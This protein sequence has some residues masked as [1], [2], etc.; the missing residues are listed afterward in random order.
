MDLKLFFAFFFALIVLFSGNALA[1]VQKDSTD[2]VLSDGSRI[3]VYYSNALAQTI[4]LNQSNLIGYSNE[5]ID[6]GNGRTK[7]NLKF[8]RSA[9]QF[10]DE[11]NVDISGAKQL[12]GN[13][14]VTENFTI[15]FSDAIRQ[16]YG[17]RLGRNGTTATIT[18]SG[19]A[20]FG[21]VITI[22]PTIIDTSRQPL[23]N[24]GNVLARDS[25]GN[26]WTVYSEVVTSSNRD[27]F[28]GKSTNGGVNFSTFNLT[29][30]SDF[31]EA[32]PHIDIN[33]TDG[34]VISYDKYFTNT[35]NRQ[36][37]I[38]TCSA[39]GCDAAAEF[40]ADINV[41][42]CLIAQLCG[43]NSLTVDQNN[44]AHIT[45]G[46]EIPAG[47][48]L[49]YRS[50]AGYTG[51][52][53][54]WSADQNTITSAILGSGSILFNNGASGAP[55]GTGVI[56]SKNG[57]GRR[58]AWVSANASQFWVSYY[59]GTAWQGGLL[60]A[61]GTID[62]PPSCYAGY[63][64][65]FFCSYAQDS[66]SGSLNEQLHFRQAN[67]DN[68][69][70][71]IGNWS[72]DTNISTNGLNLQLSSIIQTFDLNTY[73]VGSQVPT[74]A[75]ADTNIYLF[76]RLP[77]GTFTTSTIADQNRFFNDGNFLFN[78]LF[79]D[80]D[81][82]GST[83]RFPTS[84]FTGTQRYRLDYIFSTSNANTGNP[85]T[86]VF[87][88]NALNLTDINGIV[89]TFT[90]SIPSPLMLDTELGITNRRVD[91]NS[92][93]V[94]SGIID[95]NYRWFVNSTNVST[96]QNYSR[97]FNG[98]NADYNISLVVQGRSATQTFTSQA[99]L[100]YL[101]RNLAQG[102]DIN[103]VFNP[104][105][106]LA[107][108]N[109]TATTSSGTIN[110]VVW[111]FP[112]DQNQTGNPVNKQYRSGDLR[113]VCAVVNTTGDINKVYCEGF[114]NTFVLVKRPINI[115]TAAIATPYSVTV[116]SIPTQTYNNISVDQNFW[117]FYQN[118]DSNTYNL[119]VD[120]NVSYYVS[121]YLIHIKATDFNQTI[122]PY[123]VPVTTGIQ[124]TFTSKD[125]TTNNIVPNIFLFFSRNI[126][127]TGNVLVA[128]GQTD[129]TGRITLPFI[130]NVDHNF[131]IR[132]PVGAIILI[133]TYNPVS[134]DATNGVNVFIPTSILGD[135]N[136]TGF[137]D[138]NFFQNLQVPVKAN[139]TVDL[140][141][142]VT[143]THPISTITITVDHNGAVLFNQ[144]YSGVATG[145]DFNQN[146]NV[147]GLN[148][149]VPLTITY[150]IN[151]TDGSSAQIKKS[152]QIKASGNIIDDFANSR[153]D[154]GDL[155][156]TMLLSVFLIAIILGGIHWSLPS[157]DNSIT[158]LLASMIFLFLTLV[159]WVDGTSWIIG[160][161]AGGA[162]WYWGRV[163]K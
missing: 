6:L 113:V 141:Q 15:D 67:Q 34:L 30:T 39:G 51:L 110:Y 25:T 60:L 78:P 62:T 120:A 81:Y 133:G 68:N 27:I 106:A 147:S 7:W 54:N 140:N 152:I 98:A 52:V 136:S 22:D 146:V 144:T 28:I 122:Q 46:K 156:G 135:V 154:L 134:S 93:S 74:N 102:I 47:S 137:L 66:G 138:V 33:S 112:N 38:T 92:T 32:L 59:N 65:N 139:N 100:N 117:F 57:S 8:D 115:S 96:D 16:G 114:Y 12:N 10:L 128:S 101:V 149:N 53:V 131:T 84:V 9:V 159:G 29:N 132:Y 88:S 42:Q 58:L 75:P 76:T 26:I 37:F 45:Y 18:F 77:N 82:N 119:V 142:E 44:T 35:N 50:N 24:Y 41:S 125:G 148:R 19:I 160:S 23:I 90:S 130:P 63:D 161:L 21:N 107:D 86:F 2:L 153:S 43:N 104:T 31:N 123:V 162:M 111:G 70:S 71:A 40:I 20:A 64:K 151:F 5:L 97:D 143:A 109:F 158:F 13:K 3:E 108:V 145:G 80:K 124:V 116:N 72:T 163:E 48:N 129:T 73:I 127:G 85:H 99:D 83:V 157:I 14:V 55:D 56:V 49:V 1:Q 36:T 11:L 105:S 121:T 155:G 79:R 150:D 126:I 4:R 118:P 61:S 91:F 69:G 94:L 87:D 95:V 17:V 103:F 89:A